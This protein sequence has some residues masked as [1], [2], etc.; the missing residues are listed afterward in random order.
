MIFGILLSMA[1]IAVGIRTLIRRYFGDHEG[2]AGLGVVF[3]GAGIGFG[4]LIGWW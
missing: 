2:N 1:L 3:L 4:W